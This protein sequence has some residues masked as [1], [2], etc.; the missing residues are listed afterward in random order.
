VKNKVGVGFWPGL[1]KGEPAFSWYVF[2]IDTERPTSSAPKEPTEA[3]VRRA[4]EII[5]T[6]WDEAVVW[7]SP[8]R[9][10]TDNEGT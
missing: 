9:V 10:N 4:V 3:E 2:W 7:V 5:N 6:Y 1:K 8:G